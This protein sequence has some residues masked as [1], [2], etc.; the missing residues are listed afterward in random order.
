[1]NKTLTIIGGI[2]CALY[3][4]YA[5]AQQA[6]IRHADFVVTD[7]GGVP[8]VLQERTVD[9]VTISTPDDATAVILGDIGTFWTADKRLAYVRQRGNAYE[10]VYNGEVVVESPY[11]IEQLGQITSTLAYCEIIDDGT[12][13]KSVAHMGDISYEFPEDVCS[14]SSL[15]GNELISFGKYVY[16][17]GKRTSLGNQHGT[18]LDAFKYKSSI[19]YIPTFT[20]PFETRLMVGPTKIAS[21]PGIEGAIIEAAIQGGK[22]AYSIHKPDAGWAVVWGGEVVSRWHAY[23]TGFLQHAKK[24]TYTAMTPRGAM[25]F[26][27]NKAYGVGYDEIR[28][29]YETPKGNILYVTSKTSQEFDKTKRTVLQDVLWFNSTK[30]LE[31]LYGQNIFAKVVVIDGTYPLV[32]IEDMEGNPQYVWYQGHVGLRG[33]KVVAVAQDGDSIAM[34]VRYTDD[35]QE[36]VYMQ[37]E[38]DE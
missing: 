25:L 19:V 24:L 13:V 3:A 14:R 30:L 35:S 29:A 11:R 20:T 36:I 18:I 33:Q 8:V 7:V 16:V 27:G 12:P 38:Q 31:S 2:F 17:N 6:S 22:L 5:C 15:S 1:M 9:D 37:V 26:H 23:I 32:V 4:Q 10:L 21:A 34:L 28:F